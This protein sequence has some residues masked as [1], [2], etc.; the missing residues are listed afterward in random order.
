LIRMTA[1][2]GRIDAQLAWVTGLS[3]A[4]G[5]VMP[6]VFLYASDQRSIQVEKDRIKAHLLAVRLYPDQLTVVLRSYAAVLAGTG[7]YLRLAFK[8]M[9]YIVLPLTFLIAR[10]ELYLGK[11]AVRPGQPFLFTVHT[12]S[13]EVGEEVLLQPP[14]G[15]VVTAPPVH[16]A[17]DKEVVWRLSS[18][19]EGEYH[20]TVAVGGQRYE[21]RV[22]VSQQSRWLSPVRLRGAPWKRIFLSAEDGLPPKAPIESMEVDYSPRTIDLAGVKWDWI[23]LFLVLSLI[24]GFL[25]KTI[26]R[27]QV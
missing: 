1:W 27:I 21:K 17:S 14:A 3:L 16:I 2:I 10:A 11:C 25:V 8:P 13:A 22:L 24:T 23:W 19:D 9:L 26:L 18:N 5:L 20:L 4:A 12:A 15:V 7:R 6:L